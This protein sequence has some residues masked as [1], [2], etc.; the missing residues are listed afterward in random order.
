[1]REARSVAS[2]TGNLL[3]RKGGARPA[4]RPQIFNAEED[5]GW[6]D[7]GEAGGEPKPDPSPKLVPIAF[8]QPV[9]DEVPPPAVVQQQA[10]LIES[11]AEPKPRAAAGAHGKSA[12]T[13]RL[14]EER[15]LRLR[16]MGAHRHRSSQSLV[17]EALDRL[18][19]EFEQGRA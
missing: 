5:L 1:M 10:A 8:G 15:H 12:F 14:D 4:M 13:L 19:D 18:L 7:M 6:N 3:A 2:L 17:I 9:A 11:F 16:L